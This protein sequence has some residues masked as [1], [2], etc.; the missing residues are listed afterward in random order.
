MKILIPSPVVG[1]QTKK[2]DKPYRLMHY[3]VQQEVEEGVLLYNTLTCALAL[4]T[5]EEAKNLTAVEGLI[6]H[7]FLVPVDHDDKRFCKVLRI[8]AKLMQKRPKG[9]KTYTIV[10]TTGCNARCAYCFEQGIK[11]EHMTME[12]AEK[13]AQYI[14]THRGEHE[15]VKIRW[16]G[17][18]PLYN[19]KVMDCICTRLQENNIK[20]KSDIITNGY[21]FSDRMV[22]K[23]SQLWNLKRIQ[24]TIDG[25]EENYNRIKAYIHTNGINPYLRVMKNIKRLLEAKIPT[26]QIRINLDYN[27]LEDLW[28]LT[29]ECGERF[30][31]YDNFHI[32]YMSLFEYFATEEQVSI[33][34][35]AVFNEKAKLEA[36]VKSI[37]LKGHPRQYNKDNFV[38]NRCM[39]DS[40]DAIMIAHDGHLGL[41]EH[42]LD[43]HFIGHIDSKGLDQETIKQLRE[44][45]EEIPECNACAYYPK[46]YRLKICL[47]EKECFKELREEMIASIKNKMLRDYQEIK[48]SHHTK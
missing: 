22:E 28:A 32:Y 8:G 7:R 17:G 38:L 42:Y 44:Y 12:T 11:P 2:E 5:H 41:C 30:R 1:Q 33:Q 19:F 40:E 48:D 29:K 39:V 35:K 24:I 6:E 34:R 31:E 37:G 10:T 13:V 21:L 14:I 9:I 3:V 20:F 26:V 27:N 16:F 23:A 4:V 15:E 43:S 18:E 25:T 36:Y 45:C 47:T 46:C